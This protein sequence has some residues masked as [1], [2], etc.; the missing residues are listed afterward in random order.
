MI[1]LRYNCAAILQVSKRSASTGPV[2]A[3]LHW[4]GLSAHVPECEA[5]GRGGGGGGG[6]V[7]LIGTGT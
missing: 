6:L 5:R 7:R 4:S 2:E 3:N 1:R